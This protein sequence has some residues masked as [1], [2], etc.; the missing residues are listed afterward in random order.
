MPYPKYALEGDGGIDC[1]STI[2]LVLGPGKFKK[3]PLGIKFKLPKGTVALVLPKSGLGSK[4][5]I[6]VTGLIDNGYRGEVSMM[7]YNISDKP[8]GIKK[9]QK[10]CQIMVLSLP[11]IDI[12][13]DK[14]YN[15]TTR[16]DNGFGSTGLD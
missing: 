4:G 10:V 6:T 8:I 3:I 7:A 9:N 15:N 14:V 1:Y 5:L 13:Y 16:G 2:D 12:S 11:D